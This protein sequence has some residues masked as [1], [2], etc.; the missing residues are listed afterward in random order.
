VTRKPMMVAVGVL[1]VGLAMGTSS[2]RAAFPGANGRITFESHRDGNSEIYSVRRN[3]GGLVN[4]TN[5]PAND[6]EP[7]YSADGTKIAFASWRDGGG[8]SEIFIM[9]ADGSDP[10]QITHNGIDDTEPAFSPD[11]RQLVMV[12]LFGEDGD[13]ELIFIVDVATGGETFLAEGFSP[14]WSPLGDRIA[15][16]G[17]DS[18]RSDHEVITVRPDGTD[19]REVTDSPGNR[20]QTRLVS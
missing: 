10:T 16:S 13:H 5:H 7:A 12:S 15:F 4:L 9:S 11:G 8:D 14:A 3:G 1:L 2:T 18:S 6:Y 17:I 19:R 20:F